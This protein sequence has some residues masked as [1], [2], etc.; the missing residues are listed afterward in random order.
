MYVIVEVPADTPVTNPVLL[1]VATDVF[2]DTHGLKAA[3]VALPVSWVV[4]PK[5]SFN[6]PVIVGSGFTVMVI[7][8]VVAHCPAVGVNVYVVVAVLLIAGD[9]VPVMLLFD[10]VGS[11]NVPPLHIAAT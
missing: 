11:V 4:R 9:H 10:V 1:T 2:D 3:A 8:V 6:V 5:Q 7:V